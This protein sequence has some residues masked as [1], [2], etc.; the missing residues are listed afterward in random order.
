MFCR[1]ENDNVIRLGSL[2][3]VITSTR[4]CI[5]YIFTRVRAQGGVGRER[6]IKTSADE[7]CEVFMWT[8]QD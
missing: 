6:Y 2:H 8:G 3:K 5:V 1:M 4:K 7:N